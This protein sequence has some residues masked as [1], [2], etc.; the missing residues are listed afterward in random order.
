MMIQ[1]GIKKKRW[2]DLKKEKKQ[3]YD[4]WISF[5]EKEESRRDNV[6]IE[7]KNEDE[8]DAVTELTAPTTVEEKLP[9]KTNIVSKVDA[10]TTVS[11]ETTPQSLFN[12]TNVAEKT[13]STCITTPT[14]NVTPTKLTASNTKDVINITESNELSVDNDISIHDSDE[15][16]TATYMSTNPVVIVKKVDGSCESSR[17]YKSTLMPT[18]HYCVNDMP[19]SNVF[20]SDNKEREVC[21]NATCCECRSRIGDIDGKYVNYCLECVSPKINKRNIV[22]KEKEVLCKASK[23]NTSTTKRSNKKRKAVQPRK[24]SRITSGRPQRRNKNN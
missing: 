24:S 2:A 6:E 11:L 15:D 5:T 16:S 3:L 9:N 21:D 10:L 14:K 17:C 22:L 7:W 4:S 13:T 8:Q 20:F 12:D 19:G 23:T 1:R 18:N